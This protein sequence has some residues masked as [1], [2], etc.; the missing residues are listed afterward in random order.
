MAGGKGKSAGGKSS[1][2]K[3]SG[4]GPKKQQSHSARAGLQVR[5]PSK[6]FLSLCD[7]ISVVF[8][9]LC[10]TPS[11][12]HHPIR[13]LTIVTRRHR[14]RRTP[15]VATPETCRTHQLPSRRCRERHF[16]RPGHPAALCRPLEAMN[17]ARAKASPD[18]ATPLLPRFFT[19][20]H[21]HQ[22]A[23]LLT[24]FADVV[25]LRPCQA[26]PQAKHPEQDARRCQGCRVR[27]C[28]SRVPD[29]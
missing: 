2:G 6:L 7:A 29:R 25:P 24:P 19:A 9:P 15:T 11:R 5:I 10:S 23:R 14:R 18:L 28:G 8:R 27:Y 1:G 13:F 4:E 16:E 26:I 20:R 12:R 3:T 21:V 22:K 17:R